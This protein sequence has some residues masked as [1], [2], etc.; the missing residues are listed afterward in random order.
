MSSRLSWTPA[1]RTLALQAEKSMNFINKINYECNFSFITSNKLFDK[2]VIPVL[3]YG[4]EIWGSKAHSIIENP[5]LKFCRYQL[6]VSSKSCTPALLGECGKHRLYIIC[7]IKTVKYWLKLVNLSLSSLLK[8]S[9]IML[10]NL[11]NAGRQNWASEIRD[12][13]YRFGFGYVWQAQ[14]VDDVNKF[15]NEL[16]ERLYDC[17]MQEWSERLQGMPKLRTLCIFK[18]ELIV[19]PYLLLSIPYRL[20]SALAKLRTGSHDLEI[21]KGRHRN[22]PHYN[23]LCKLCNTLNLNFIEDEY[24]VIMQCPFYTDLRNIYLRTEQLPINLHIDPCN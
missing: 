22:I 11:C 4:S 14:G 10:Y 12:I 13:L 7:Y 16:K 18:T 3:T 24:H 2:C 19:E 6:G 23:R 5:L 17:D 9:Y 21:E 8:S 15:L 1:Q 20:R